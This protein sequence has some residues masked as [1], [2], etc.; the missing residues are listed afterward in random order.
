LAIRVKRRI[1][2]HRLSRRLIDKLADLVLVLRDKQATR[3]MK[4]VAVAAIV[5]F[6]NPF[7]LIPDALPFGWVDDLAVATAAIIQLRKMGYFDR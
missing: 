6:L 4:M 7:D 1:G 3:P 2:K 5:Y